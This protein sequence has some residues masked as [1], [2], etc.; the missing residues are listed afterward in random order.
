MEQSCLPPRDRASERAGEAG[1]TPS[2]GWLDGR[3]REKQKEFEQ[4]CCIH[5]TKITIETP[6]TEVL[7]RHKKTGATEEI[8]FS[9]EE[10]L[11]G[12]NCQISKENRDFRP[13]KIFCPGG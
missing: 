3:K 2:V 11:N 4:K 6:E 10:G 9:P 7:L 13:R 12:K 1:K 5:L 8:F